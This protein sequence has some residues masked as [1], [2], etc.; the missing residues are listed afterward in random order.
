[1]NV[2]KMKDMMKLS[3]SFVTFSLIVYSEREFDGMI[4]MI[5]MILKDKVSRIERR[6]ENLFRK[7]EDDD[8]FF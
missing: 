8:D 2:E 3:F 6:E 4:E 1:M 7:R 5:S